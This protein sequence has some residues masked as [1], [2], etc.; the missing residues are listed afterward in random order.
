MNPYRK[1]FAALLL[2]GFLFSVFGILVRTLGEVFTDY[3]QVFARMV[4]VVILLIPILL[5][6]KEN[7]IISK[8]YIGKILL[9]SF[10]VLISI[11]FFTISVGQ[12]KVSSAVFLLYSGNILASIVIGK[13]FFKENLDRMKIIAFAFCILGI[14]AFSGNWTSE[15]LLLPILL[16]VFSGVFEAGTHALR[17]SLKDLSRNT[18]LF[19]QYAIGAAFSFVF[20]FTFSQG[21]TNTTVD[22]KS[23]AI[24]ILFA[25]L[26]LVVGNLLLYGFKNFD[27]NIGVIVLSSEL[28]FS[29]IASA[30]LLNEIP[31]LNEIIGALFIFIAVVIVNVR[32]EDLKLTRRKFKLP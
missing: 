10:L 28:L 22:L 20:S 2:S 9:F 17:K 16:A 27:L 19:Y 29:I 18:V 26:L 31:S 13:L 21:I 4:F 6:K 14:S 7:I 12:L 15:F 11:V 1:G 24:V 32:M 5:F 30:L 3:G 8:N 23:L 25:V